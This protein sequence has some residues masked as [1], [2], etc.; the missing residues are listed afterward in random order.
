ML[1]GER[2]VRIQISGLGQ[3][4]PGWEREGTE[5]GLAVEDGRQGC[6]R[7]QPTIQ[8]AT[9]PAAQRSRG[10]AKETQNAVRPGGA[11]LAEVRRREA[12]DVLSVLEEGGVA[13]LSI[14]RHGTWRWPAG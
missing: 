9:S 6:R 10:S 2:S 13:W 7:R 12:D 1:L 5:G 3:R 11:G 8:S 4:R 14:W